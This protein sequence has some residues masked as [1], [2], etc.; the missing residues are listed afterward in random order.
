MNKQSSKY[1]RILNV[2]NAGHRIR[3]PAQITELLLMQRH[4][5]RMKIPEY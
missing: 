4:I 2:F 3:S 5:L 1:A